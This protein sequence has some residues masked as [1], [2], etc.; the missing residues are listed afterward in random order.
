MTVSGDRTCWKGCRALGYILI[1]WR[2]KPGIEAG[3]W[4][5]EVDPEL[6]MSLDQEEEMQQFT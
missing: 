4:D 2:W 3:S 6:L 1:N 5:F